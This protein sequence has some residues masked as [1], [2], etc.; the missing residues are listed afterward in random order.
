M[1]EDESKAAWEGLL[2]CLEN[3]G[4][5]RE[6]G[7]ELIVHDG[8]KGL[9]AAL[10]FLYPTVPH[11]R[12]VFHKLRS[13]WQAIAFSDDLSS[14]QQRDL[15][16]TLIRQAAAVYYAGSRAAA[17]ALVRD[18]RAQWFASCLPFDW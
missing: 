16:T 18:F 5:Y 6:R 11:Q 4:V 9:A 2:T 10:N 3:R 14:D 13:I 8:G 1:A 15:K 7:L 12:C 17:L